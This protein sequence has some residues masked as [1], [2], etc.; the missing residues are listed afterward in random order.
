MKRAP[1]FL[2]LVFSLIIL[3]CKK[4]KATVN[5]NPI[6]QT[7]QQ[8]VFKEYWD[9][10]DR[11]YPLMYRK[12]INWQ[13]VY[14]TYSS[15][16]SQTTTDQQLFDMF[17]SIFA[18]VL[19]DGHSGLSLNEE[20][21]QF[22]PEMNQ[23]VANMIQQN[24]ASKVDIVASSSS[25]PYISY[26][27]L[28]SNP[29]I[30]Y[31]LSKQFEPVN[32]NESEFDNFKFIV[33]AALDALKGKEGI[34]VDVRTNGGGQGPFAY[35]LAGRFF[36]NQNT[37]T[38]VRMRVKAKIGSSESSLGEWITENFEGYPDARA[39][40]GTIGS[41]WTGDFTVRASGSYQFVKK[42]A[43]LTSKGT[44]SAAEYFTAA[45]K[46]QSHIKTIGEQTF[47]IFAGSE[48]LTLT[49][50]GEKW[51]TR[52]SVQD[53]EMLYDGNYQSFEGVGISPDL[54][55]IP[56]QIQV[57]EGLDT[58]IDEAIKYIKQVTNQSNIKL[59]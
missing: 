59:F 20:E 48:H 37:I 57:E 51:T 31:I 58:H 9:I 30:G 16:I 35:Y 42:V 23:D 52:V 2:M 41:V 17:N 5:E 10:Y 44:A 14:D 13:E 38:L 26:G 53:V 49:N 4:D 18:T 15:Q 24:T 8:K 6:V 19:K 54:V 11:Y 43:V 50:G 33:D 1:I 22:E 29:E 32:E 7:E 39:E 34:I 40:E 28:K 47:G 25:N 55:S 21:T 36:S 45:M 3:S 27:T 12:S 46:T 56:S